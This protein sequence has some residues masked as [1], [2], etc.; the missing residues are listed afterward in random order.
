MKQISLTQGQFALV[1]DEF[2]EELNKYKWNAHW[3]PESKNFYAVRR[4]NSKKGR[5]TIRMH[6]VIM[7]TPKWMQVD[8]KDGNGLNNQ[9]DNLRNAPQC[10]NQWNTGIRSTNTSGF[11][12]VCWHKCFRKW[13]ARIWVDRKRI[14]LGLF[15]FSIDAAE[16]WN[17]AALLYHGEFAFQN[18]LSTNAII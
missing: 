6:R 15:D 13:Y 2:F 11:K 1:P 5:P 14:S 17:K 7:K 9:L 16:A 18:K 3:D 12:G 10:C 4:D 8:H